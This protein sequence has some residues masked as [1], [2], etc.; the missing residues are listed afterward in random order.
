M[1]NNN[2]GDNHHDDIEN[3]YDNESLDEEQQKQFYKNQKNFFKARKDIIE[4]PEY[5][6]ED[7][8]NDDLIVGD[9]GKNM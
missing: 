6:E 1:D 2:K 5:L 9:G 8:A 4:E 3:D 7:N